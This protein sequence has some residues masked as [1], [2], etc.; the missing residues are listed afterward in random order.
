M[1]FDASAR[2]VASGSS[3]DS[4]F[5]LG[6]LGLKAGAYFIRIRVGNQSIVRKVLVVD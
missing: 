5:V 1:V 2:I 4:S 6:T 3:G